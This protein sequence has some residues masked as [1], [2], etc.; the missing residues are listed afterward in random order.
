MMMILAAVE[1]GDL[2]VEEAAVKLA[3]LD[4][5]TDHAPEAQSEDAPGTAGAKTE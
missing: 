3:E 2:T 5:L 1:K 4:R